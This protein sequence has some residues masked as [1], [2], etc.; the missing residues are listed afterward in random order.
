MGR[1]N[2]RRNRKKVPKRRRRYNSSC[3]RAD[4]E[5]ISQ[6]RPD[7]GLGLSHLQYE[8]PCH[9]LIESLPARQ[10]T[11]VQAIVASPH[12]GLRP[13]HQKSTC[14]AQ[15]TVGHY[16]VQMWSRYVRMN[17]TNELHRWGWPHQ[18]DKTAPKISDSRTKLS[19][20]RFSVFF[21]GLRKV[22]KSTLLDGPLDSHGKRERRGEREC[23]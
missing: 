14:I 15:S 1:L 9:L 22:A 13:F 21:C 19:T 2:A 17:E 5:Q 12:G 6:S 23:V 10:R 20:F 8:S 18:N 7:S 3:C 11:S 4:S 16:L